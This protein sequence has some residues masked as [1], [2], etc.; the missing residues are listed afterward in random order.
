[1]RFIGE[2]TNR[3]ITSG[4]LFPS[5]FAAKIDESRWRKNVSVP[6]DRSY[7][8][9]DIFSKPRTL[10]KQIQL[11]KLNNILK[12]QQVSKLWSFAWNILGIWM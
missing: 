7:C 12:L 10:S 1:M 11:M 9:R 3:Q 8:P 4:H 5:F 2:G 6:G